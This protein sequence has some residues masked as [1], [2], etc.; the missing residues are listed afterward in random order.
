MQVLAKGFALEIPGEM[1]IKAGSGAV[2]G[3][4]NA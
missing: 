4:T 1:N 3:G 2:A